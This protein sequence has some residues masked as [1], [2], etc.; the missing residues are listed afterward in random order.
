MNDFSEY[1]GL[2]KQFEELQAN[3]PVPPKQALQELKASTNDGR[4]K[5]SEKEMATLGP[6]V[7]IQDFQIP[8]RD[9]YSIEARTY[10]S[11]SAPTDGSLPLFIHL[12]GGG[13]LFGTLSSE[14]ANCSRVAINAPVVVLNVNYRHSPEHTY[15]TAWNDTEDA[16]EWAYTNAKT[17]GANSQQVIIGG[18]SAGS[19]LTSSLVQARH[20]SRTPSTDSIV[21]HIL[22]IP[23]S[24]HHANSEGLI[25][26][27]KSPE[28]SSYVQNENAPILSKA[29]ID[30]FNNLVF[31]EVPT[32]LRANPGN[33]S[34][35]Q[36]KG[37]PPAVFGI[38]GADPL[39]DQGLLYA[40][41]LASNGVP[42][43]VHVYKGLPHGFRRFGAQL[44]EAS[45][46]WDETITGAFVGS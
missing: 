11:K 37:L 8:A 19:W 25:K 9:G 17:L 31:P 40:Q 13:F 34:A 4:E 38:A 7:V 46:A 27:L 15:P 33:A 41:L 39:R 18:I 22:M 26:H 12:H 28:V 30:L 21:G 10:R 35:E 20:R 6:Q 16:F 2:T 24:V 36:V 44:Q 43:N 3:Q 23:P 1:G 45:T 5:A 32:E 29:R 14:D 42:T